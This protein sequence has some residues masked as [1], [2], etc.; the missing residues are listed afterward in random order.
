MTKSASDTD[1]DELFSRYFSKASQT[2]AGKPLH[3]II[4]PPPIPVGGAFYAVTHS[5]RKYHNTRMW[6][7]AAA[8]PKLSAALVMFAPSLSTPPS[9]GDIPAH[10]PPGSTHTERI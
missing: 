7:L 1:A 6:F 5:Q 4:V 8:L 9:R 3:R 2:A 10:P